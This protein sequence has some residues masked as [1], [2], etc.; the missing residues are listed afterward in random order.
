VFFRKDNA[1]DNAL[2][3]AMS[4]ELGAA[5]PSPGVVG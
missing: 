1:L 2:A 5:S 3:F 4:D